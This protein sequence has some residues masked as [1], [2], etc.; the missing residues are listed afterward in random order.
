[1]LAVFREEGSLV[2]EVDATANVVSFVEWGVIRSPYIT[3]RK[4]PPIVAMQ[5]PRLW[6]PPD[7]PRKTGSLC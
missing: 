4:N 6:L 3:R 1:M 7:R 5:P 2:S